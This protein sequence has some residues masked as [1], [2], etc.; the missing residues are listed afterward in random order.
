MTFVSIP[1][2]FCSGICFAFI[3]GVY[4]AGFSGLVILL[5]LDS[6]HRFFG[7]Y[8]LEIWW[9][10][11]KNNRTPLLC[12]VKLYASF[13]SHWWIQTGV[14]IGKRPIRVKISKFC[15][16]S[17][18][19]LTNNIEKQKGTSSVLHQAFCIISLPSVNSNWSY[20]LEM[21]NSGK[22]R[23]FFVTCDLEIWW[24]IL[25]NNRAPLLCYFKLC[26]SFHSHQ[27][28]ITGIRVKIGDFLSHATLKFDEWP[29][30]TIGH[31][32]CAI[33]SS[34]HHFGAIGE[35]ELELQSGDA[36]FGWKSAIFGRMWPWN[37]TDGLSTLLQAVCVIL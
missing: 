13:Q 27:W 12:Y 2:K 35:F 1:S 11:S 8:N 17:P 33:S 30:K 6:N 16:V 21:L 3:L 4:L 14:T 37:L 28:I 10:T 5:K 29:W 23:W 15:P 26:A 31:L 24:M 20:S 36:Q 32:F 7:P 18:W 22:N 34:V 9:M 25:K 19:N